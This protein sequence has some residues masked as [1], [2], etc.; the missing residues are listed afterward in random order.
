MK[1][2]MLNEKECDELREKVIKEYYPELKILKEIYI[3][4][5]IEEKDLE[6]DF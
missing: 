5:Q 6:V 4:S 2:K 1:S 3:S